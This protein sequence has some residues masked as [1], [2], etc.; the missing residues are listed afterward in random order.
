MGTRFDFLT[1]D[2]DEDFFSSAKTFIINELERIEQKFSRYNEA[3]EISKINKLSATESVTTDPEIILI[4]ALCKEYYQK[5]NKLF[6]ITVGMFTKHKDEFNQAKGKNE[7]NKSVSVL[8][9]PDFENGSVPGVD[10]IIL[11]FEDSIVR[12][13]NPMISID[14]GGIGKG[15]AIEIIKKY[16]TENCIKNALIGFG[17][18]SI[19]T[20]ESRPHGDYWPIGIQHAFSAGSPIHAFKLN[21]SSLS[22]SG[23]TPNN[24]LKFGS[25]GHIINPLTG[26]F[27]KESKAVSVV[28]HSPIEA[29]VLSTALFLANDN[30]KAAIF[31]RFNPTESIEIF[32]NEMNEHKLINLNQEYNFANND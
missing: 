24:Q 12:F 14:L 23:N 16:C 5:T 10:N 25:N 13:L 2:L 28:T 7:I 29:E 15:Y 3:S 1:Y 21:N 20:L 17:D 30:D 27:Q 32:Y 4:L 22:T 6:D 8:E 31:S 11:N 18:S 26:E 19:T 9:L